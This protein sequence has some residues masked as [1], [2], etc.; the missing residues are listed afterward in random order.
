AVVA[1]ARDVLR[2]AVG[3]AL[4][5]GLRPAIYG[6]GWEGLVDPALVVADYVPNATLPVVYSSIGVLL[7]D[8]WDAMRAWGIVSNRIFDA[9]ACGT[10]VISDFLP[11]VR[12]LFGDSV[13]MYQDSAELCSLVEAAL[14]DPD[15]AK[16]R[17]GEARACVRTD[18]SF[19]QRAR[20]FLA[21]LN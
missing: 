13:P 1:K 15:A 9:L 4:A 18:H 21:A 8:H 7:A 6:S 12:E 14:A 17:A 19:D 11:E 3:D 16:R 20:Q 10:P 5:A 2:R